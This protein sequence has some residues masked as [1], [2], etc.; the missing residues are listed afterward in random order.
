MYGQKGGLGLGI[1]FTPGTDVKTKN[2]YMVLVPKD[3]KFADNLQE[4]MD[5]YLKYKDR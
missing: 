4:R 3:A 1:G 2:V 5:R